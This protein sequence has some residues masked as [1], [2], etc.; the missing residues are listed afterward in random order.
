MINQTWHITFSNHTSM[1]QINE[2]EHLQIKQVWDKTFTEQETM[3]Q[4]IY[5][6]NKNEIEHLQ[7]KQEWDRT[8]TN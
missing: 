2:T 4:N 8:F 6:P 3:R 7:T 1:R 5:R